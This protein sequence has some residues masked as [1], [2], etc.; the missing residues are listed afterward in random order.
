MSC[1]YYYKYMKYK[2]KYTEAFDNL[3]KTN[4]SMTGGGSSDKIDVMLFKADWCG[5]CKDFKPTWEQLESQYSKKFN[6][7]T[8]DSAENKD[9]VDE[10]KVKGFPTIIFKDGDTIQPYN[11]PRE[12]EA[13]QGI[14]DNLVKI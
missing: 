13:L 2:T 12:F 8:Y 6:F 1:D 3:N 14:L 4:I 7:I 5:H 9:K 10:M 11:G